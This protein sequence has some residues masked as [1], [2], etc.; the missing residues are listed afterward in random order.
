MND[1]SQVIIPKS[2]Q[3][4]AD[5]L[6]AGPMTVTIKG[7]IISGGQEQPVSIALVETPLFYRPCK[8]MS[9]VLVGAWGADASKYVGRALTL[10]RDPSVKWGGMEVGG[11]RISHMSH[12]EGA[13]TMVLT[14]T[15]GSRK[16]H[17]ILPLEV[18]AQ[19]PANGGD[20]AVRWVSGYIAKLGT[21]TTAQQVD[22]FATEKAA[23][24]AELQEARPELYSQVRAASAERRQALEPA[25]QTSS[26]D[27]DLTEDSSEKTAAEI[28]VDQYIARAEA[29]AD[30]AA[31]T[32]I[33]TEADPHKA[34]LSDE[35]ALKLEI[36]F[37]KAR[38]RLAPTEALV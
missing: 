28:A 17:K 9:R 32:A 13:R 10:Y 2:D 19:P 37:D 22:D 18:P 4:N 8:S 21:F 24:L 1:M 35:L 23:K 6:I 14:A 31:L 38:Q 5:S 26:F 34:F 27:D 20:P 7:V 16:P 30:D 15:K 25:P 11:I 33:I 3:I 12:I 36:A 29:A